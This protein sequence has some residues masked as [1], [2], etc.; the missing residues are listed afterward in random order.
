M[1]S[2]R[3]QCM[4]VGMFNRQSILVIDGKIR[5]FLWKDQIIPVI[6]GSDGKTGTKVISGRQE[7]Q[8]T[9]SR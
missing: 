6:D 3:R 1:F 9:Q 5:L 2:E 4:M 7:T 8:L